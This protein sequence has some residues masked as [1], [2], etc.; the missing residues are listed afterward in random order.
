MGIQFSVYAVPT[1]RGGIL[2]E[3][4]RQR[5]DS[6]Y[7]ANRFEDF[8]ANGKEMGEDSSSNVFEDDVI[9]KE[10]V[11]NALA[12]LNE[13]DRMI[14]LLFLNGF[15]QKEISQNMKISGSYTKRVI[16]QFYRRVRNS[17]S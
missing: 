2:N 1:I 3:L 9:L 10:D 5:K 14:I 6:L 7:Q 16:H 11:S 13:R 15:K 8:V 4:R 12:E 17:K